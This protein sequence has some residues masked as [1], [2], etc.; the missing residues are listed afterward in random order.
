MELPCFLFTSIPHT[1]WQQM[2]QAGPPPE[3]APAQTH[4]PAPVNIH[5]AAGEASQPLRGSRRPEEP[6]LEGGGGETLTRCAKLKKRNKYK[7]RNL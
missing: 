7:N 1:G 2:I 4:V 3:G 5:W 6:G